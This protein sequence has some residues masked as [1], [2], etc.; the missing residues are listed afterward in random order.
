MRVCIVGHGPSLLSGHGGKEIDSYDVVVRLKRCQE[1][2]KHPKFYG[3]RTDIV[4]GS[5]TIAPGLKGIGG[6]R[7]YW[8]F[9]DSRHD[10]VTPA[11]IDAM[12]RHFEPYECIID[13]PLCD[14][15]Q[16]VYRGLRNSVTRSDGMVMGRYSDLELGHNHMSQ[17]SIAVIHAMALLNPEVITLAGFD[18]VA[19]GEFT[20]SVT[21]GPEW[22]QYPDH[23]W[24]AEHVLL[25]LASDEFGVPLQILLPEKEEDHEIRHQL[26]A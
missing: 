7:R 10:N 25:K 4:G 5:W 13:R 1:T 8:V 16:A 14:E 26:W 9:L 3:S 15:W 12:K 22:E 2:L 20:W 23:N 18:S 19:N 11:M 24:A 21:R 6:A 17:G